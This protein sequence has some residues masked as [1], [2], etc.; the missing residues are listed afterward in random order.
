MALAKTTRPTQAGILV[1]PRLL[2]R[3]DLARKKPVTWVWA[4]PG[5]GKTTL[6]ASYLAARKTRGLWYQVDEGDAD[7]ATFFYYLGLAAPRRRRPLPL[8]T[9]EYRQG[10]AVFARRFFRELYSR[11]KLPFT[12]V[13]DNYQDVPPDSAL[14]DVMAETVGEIPKGGRLVFISRSDP[15]PAFARHRVHQHLEILDW[16][17]LRFTPTE[18]A[19][20]ARK[21]APGRWPR[22]TIR[23]LH[24]TADG[25]CAGL[26]LLLDQL[27]SEGR[28][29]PAPREPSSEVL[30]DYFAGEIFKKADP[31]VQ[32]VL[33]HTAF[34][35]QVTPAMAVALTGETAAGEILTALH[36]QNYFTNKQAIGGEPVYEY[37]PLFRDFLLS[38][39]LRVYSPSD[40]AR[41]QPD[42]GGPP[43]RR[44]RR[45][46]RRP[47]YCATPRTGTPS[48]S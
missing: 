3:L 37:H 32:D 39:A 11:L 22:E 8:L 7:V 20:L 45:S 25:W 24:D 14:H 10:V 19:E 12:V 23:S 17:Q 30:F 5:A 27:R 26:V 42:G 13:F 47:G 36:E 6:V 31:T 35:P 48:H 28:A 18:A 2:R 43:P 21:L 40:R 41:I 44:G 34:L 15:P 4:P 33:L 1:R 29:S 38:Q 16:S 9:P 46:R